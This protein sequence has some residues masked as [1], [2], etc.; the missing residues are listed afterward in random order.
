MIQSLG[1]KIFKILGN[2]NDKKKKGVGNIS[3]GFVRKRKRHVVR[4][5]DGREIWS[6][7]GNATQKSRRLGRT[8][9]T[10]NFGLLI[11]CNKVT[12]YMKSM[13]DSQVV[14]FFGMPED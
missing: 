3:K 9:A 4:E 13:R 14:E 10:Q 6:C 2:K 11:S 8:R 7:S 1:N 12:Y 5:N